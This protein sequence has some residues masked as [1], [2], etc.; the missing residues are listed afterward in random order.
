MDQK[1]GTEK[2][3]YGQILKSSA[4]IGGSSVLNILISIVRTKAIALM[5]G[6]AGFG[7]MGIYTSIADL[8]RSIAEMGINNSGVRQIAEAAGTSDTKRI[9]VTIT[10]LRRT[11]VF[12]GILGATIMV[13]FSVPISKLT[14]GTDD[15]APAVALLSL[16]VLFKLVADGQ[17]ALLQGM[18]RIADL[19]RIGVL[20]A[21]IGTC[22][23]IPLVWYLGEDGIAL[24]VVAIAGGSLITSWWYSRK[25][26]IEPL[27]ISR[28]RVR[29]EVSGLLKLGVAFMLSSLLMMATAYVVRTMILRM[30]D[31]EAAGLYQAAWTMGGLYIGIILQAMGADFYPRLTAVAE[32]NGEVNRLVNEQTYISLLLAGPGVIATMAFAPLLLTL[33]YS[34]HFNAAT[35]LLRW[36]C[37]GV[38]LRVISWPIGYIIIAKGERTIFMLTEMAW[39]TVNVG[40]T[41]WALKQY[42]LNGAGMAFFASYVFHAFM[43]YAVVRRLCDFRW[44]TNNLKTGVAYLCLIIALFCGFIFLP[45]PIAIGLAILAIT[46]SGM[47]SV[48]VLAKLVP[49]GQIPGP[50]KRLLVTLRL[51]KASAS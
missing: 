18:R 47:H 48:W 21:L 28:N 25:V 26:L 32:N 9:A 10:V 33:F 51:A 36:I 35:D 50:I 29:H 11:T 24:S 14:F 34:N 3:S 7:L 30:E 45:P 31:L 38:S 37:L 19:A 12:L 20:G 22:L 15:K 39:A 46:C 1:V 42:G 41:W 6:P 49:A 5:L 40:L 2:N 17:G 4:L 43:I 44:S 8:V 23:S 27:T 13:G 16:A